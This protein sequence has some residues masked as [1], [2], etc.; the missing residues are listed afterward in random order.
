M[1]KLTKEQAITEHRKMWRWIAEETEKRKRAVKKLEYLYIHGFYEDI[2]FD[3]F[4]C[5]YDDQQHCIQQS[6]FP[7]CYFCPID[8][9]SAATSYMCKDLTNMDDDYGLFAEWIEAVKCDDWRTAAA[10][11]RQIAEL[12]ER[13]AD[14]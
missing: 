11:A 3:C 8:W 10:L 6:Y 13:A 9:D 4:C 12:P 5:E 14:M 1:M 7:D 2:A